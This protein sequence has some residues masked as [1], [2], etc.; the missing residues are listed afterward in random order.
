[1]VSNHRNYTQDIR[2]YSLRIIQKCIRVTYT[3]MSDLSLAIKNNIY[4]LTKF[5]L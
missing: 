4:G 1:M 2:K 3:N 5:V